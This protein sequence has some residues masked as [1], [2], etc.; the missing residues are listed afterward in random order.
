MHHPKEK[1]TINI[2]IAS[3]GG[4]GLAVILYPAETH[5]VRVY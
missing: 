1:Y 3:L 2:Q 5:D 4:K